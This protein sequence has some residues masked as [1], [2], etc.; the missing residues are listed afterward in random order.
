MPVSPGVA[1]AKALRLDEAPHDLEFS[2]LPAGASSEE[3]RRFERAC[4]ASIQEL[5][6]MFDEFQQ[7]ARTIFESAQKHGTLT[8]NPDAARLRAYGPGR[9]GGPRDEV[10]KYCRGIGTDVAGRNVHEE[11]H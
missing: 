9:A 11:Q 5:D 3:F 1:I 10:R 2:G 7:T 4:T 8:R 6:P